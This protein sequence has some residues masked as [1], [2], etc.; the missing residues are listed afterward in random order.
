MTVSFSPVF[1][2]DQNRSLQN[3]NWF[4]DDIDLVSL[5]SPPGVSGV[6]DSVSGLSCS[7]WLLRPLS[8]APPLWLLA[9]PVSTLSVYLCLV[10][11]Q[12]WDETQ[13]DTGAPLLDES[14]NINIDDIWIF[15]N[16]LRGC[17]VMQHATLQSLIN[18]LYFK[19]C[20][21]CRISLCLQTQVRGVHVLLDPGQQR[22]ESDID[23]GVV[24]APALLHVAPASTRKAQQDVAAGMLVTW[25]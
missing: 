9:G 14:L 2:T 11:L 13:E 1:P 15:T 19:L 22:L 20:Q 12:S 5:A 23:G 24:D 7:C 18:T 16:K 6:S 4:R 25:E 3:M 21:W 17:V 8:D 10:T